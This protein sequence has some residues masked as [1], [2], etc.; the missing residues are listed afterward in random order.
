[1]VLLF[2]F[3][4]PGPGDVL[5]VLKEGLYPISR[6]FLALP[7]PVY[8]KNFAPPHRFPLLHPVCSLKPLHKFFF[9]S[10]TPP[11]GTSILFFPPR[12]SHL[13]L[14][15]KV[16]V[17]G[18]RFPWFSPPTCAQSIL[19]PTLGMAY[20][21]LPPPP[22]SSPLSA[23]RT[24]ELYNGPPVLPSFCARWRLSFLRSHRR[25]NPLILGQLLLLLS[26]SPCAALYLFVEDPPEKLCLS[27]DCDLFC[28]TFGGMNVKFPA[29]FSCFLAFQHLLRLLFEF[30]L[31]YFS[32][33]FT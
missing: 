16:K 23:S 22:P 27:P 14:Q 2:F 8:I 28:I 12:E 17:W 29:D 1:M 3:P 33:A 15:F 5:S 32:T 30:C 11:P 19:V 4:P 21:F 20:F 9:N 26:P 18:V 6:V 10:P 7:D 31:F 25:I 24:P 13:L